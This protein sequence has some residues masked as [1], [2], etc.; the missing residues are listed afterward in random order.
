MLSPTGVALN[1]D[2]ETACLDVILSK[3]KLKSIQFVSQ[4][5][6]DNIFFFGQYKVYIVYMWREQWENTFGIISL[7]RACCNIQV[8]SR[9]LKWIKKTCRQIIIIII[10]VNVISQVFE[11]TFSRSFW[12]GN[13]QNNLIPNW[14]RKEPKIRHGRT[15]M[16]FITELASAV[17]AN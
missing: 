14:K 15:Q 13:H 9:L 4:K 10:I 5:Y 3:L 1:H 8:P 16:P 7:K 6:I 2:I 12:P 11:L 17:T